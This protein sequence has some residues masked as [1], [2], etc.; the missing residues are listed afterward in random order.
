MPKRIDAGWVIRPAAGPDERLAEMTYPR[1]RHLFKPDKPWPE[2]MTC[3]AA[4]D[5]DAPVGLLL[6]TPS[7]THLWILS[8]FVAPHRRRQGIGLALLT[9]SEQEARRQNRIGMRAQHVNRMVCAAQ[10]EALL[11]KAGWPAPKAEMV[12]ITGR[13]AWAERDPGEWTALFARLHREGY[14]TQAFDDCTD[15]D[16]AEIAAVGADA[17]ER[18]RFDMALTP[19]PELSLVIRQQD[20][21]VGWILGR[22]A[23]EPNHVH[24]PVGYVVPRLQRSGWLIAALVDICRRQSL[25]RGPDSIACYETTADNVGMRGFMERRLM[26][27]GDLLRSDIQYLSTR[28]FE[29]GPEPE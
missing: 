10:W 23:L 27:R 22:D 4:W 19:T 11:I 14:S 25:L 21:I 26:A 3:L 12:R 15:A 7:E 2:E 1:Y 24:Y 18:L 8:V 28:S 17:P 16:K 9:H 20:R 5:E 13:A 6:A 29:A